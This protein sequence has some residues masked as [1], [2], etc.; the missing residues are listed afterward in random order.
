[1]NT[2]RFENCEAYTNAQ[3]GFNAYGDEFTITMDSCIARQNSGSGFYISPAKSKVLNSQSFKNGQIGLFITDEATVTNNTIYENGTR[4]LRI[5]GSNGTFTKNY[6]HSNSQREHAGSDNVEISAKGSNNKVTG[7]TIKAG[8][9][10]KKPRY[11]IYVA[12][13]SCA[14][15]IIA[16]ND[17]AGSGVTKDVQNLG[18]GTVL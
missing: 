12:A 9:L 15:N 13:S 17:A 7:N 5:Y 6:I 16:P 18:T 2:H 11:G 1:M 10:V 14:N 4:G 8:S 3:D